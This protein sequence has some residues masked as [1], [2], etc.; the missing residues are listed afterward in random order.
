MKFLVL[1]VLLL[2]ALAAAG[3]VS[4]CGSGNR[5]CVSGSVTTVTEVLSL[6][7]DEEVV[8]EYEV[9][10]TNRR[11]KCTSNCE[12]F[13]SSATGLP[14]CS[15]CTLPN[16]VYQAQ[17]INGRQQCYSIPTD[18]QKGVLSLTKVNQIKDQ[19]AL[20]AGCTCSSET[21]KDNYGVILIYA[22]IETKIQKRLRVIMKR[23]ANKLKDMKA[24]VAWFQKINKNKK[25]TEQ[26]PVTVE[27]C[28]GYLE[29]VAAA[30]RGKLE[31]LETQEKKAAR[32]A[33]KSLKTD[34]DILHY[35]ARMK[36]RISNAVDAILISYEKDGNRCNKILKQYREFLQDFKNM[37]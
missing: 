13:G 16:I 1:L 2:C 33:L 36:K 18:I 20:L 5:N 14:F 37:F 9:L 30:I 34:R 19:C 24:A 10:G 26:Q 12:W 25:R 23:Y 21:I 31:A 27:E 4:Y 3:P 6:D 15:N 29:S 8:Q 35:I 17:E 11:N 22:A 32:D 7:E 28:L